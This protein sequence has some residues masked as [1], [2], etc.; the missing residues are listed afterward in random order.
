ML[1]KGSVLALLALAS[2]VVAVPYNHFGS[3]KF[4]VRAVPQKGHKRH[5]PKAMKYVMEKY[6]FEM[7]ETLKAADVQLHARQTAK[8][9]TGSVQN[10][11]AT[12]YD[13]EYLCPVKIGTQTMNMNF[14]TG[15]ADLWVFSTSTSPRGAHTNV[16]SPG[17]TARRLPGYWYISYGDS[18]SAFGN[19]YQDTV[20]IGGVT[21]AKQGVEAALRV[22]GS[23]VADTA[24]N[25]LVGLAFSSI[26]TVVPYRQKT[27]AENALSQLASPIFTANL[28]HNAVGS[29]DFGFVNSSSFTG[30]LSYTAVNSANGFWQFPTPSYTINGV[31]YTDSSSSSAIADTGTTLLL[32]SNTIAANYYAQVNG[33]SYS[34]DAAGY[35]FPCGTVLPSITLSVGNLTATIPGSLLSYATYSGSTCYGALQGYDGNMYIYGD[36]FFKQ[37][38]TVFDYGS[39]GT[40]RIGIASK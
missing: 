36:I 4:S 23:F 18:S 38:F 31:T 21:V 9:V 5:G 14:D 29:Y 16:Y 6:G 15:S 17:R 27:F 13:N 11:P 10:T 35:L 34:D 28:K 25:G 19:V 37:Y 12:S 39:T 32:V 33:S 24:S 3:S 40:T 26:N 22:S 2:E 20:T 7:P 8:K 30:N 1:V